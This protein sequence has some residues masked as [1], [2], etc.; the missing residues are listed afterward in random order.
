LNNRKIGLKIGPWTQDIKRIDKWGADFFELYA[1]Q[2]LEWLAGCKTPVK[3]VHMAHFRDGVNPANPARRKRNALALG[4]ALSLAN[5]TGAKK[6]ILHPELKEGP[7]CSVEAL[8]DFIS[9]S[10]DSRLLI[11]NMPYSSS[12]QSHYCS[13]PDEIKKVIEE[14]KIGF[15]LDYPHA[16]EYAARLNLD[17]EML[18]KNFLALK[19][20]HFHLAD[21]DLRSVFKEQYNEEHLNLW[22]GN[23]PLELI[24]KY[25][26]EDAQITLETPKSKKQREEM[27]YLRSL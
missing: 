18:L 17:L 26:P 14:T 5:Q 6:I 23:L 20:R 15:C 3:V 2:T 21:T 16:A 9:S 25:I 7:D 10:Y 1:S 22:E 8:V 24:R 12:G 27:L 19:P 11:E 13:S 4:L